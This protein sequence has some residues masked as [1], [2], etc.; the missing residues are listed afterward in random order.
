[1]GSVPEHLA[2]A[3]ALAAAIGSAWA[4]PVAA[5][6]VTY[7]GSLSYSTGSYVFTERTHSFWISNG[8]GVR[9]GRVYLAATLP[10]VAQNSG[11]VT[12]VGGHPLPTGGE[13]NGAV[14]GRGRG[15]RIGSGTSQITDSTVVFRNVY[16]VEVGDPMAS[17]SIEAFQGVGVVRSLSIQAGAKA[18]LRTLESGV[19]TG[20]WDFGGGLS[21]IV[22]SGRT[23]A[24]GDVSYWHFGDLPELELKGSVLYSVGVSRS[25]WDARGSVVVTLAGAS[26][27]MDSVDPPLSLGVGLSYLPRAG[28]SLS[29][30]AS[31]GLTEASP[32]FSSWVG[33]G[34][35]L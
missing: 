13:Q 27:I 12:F 14:S 35:G 1:M 15:M 6:Q 3:V 20:E 23:L 34:V 24:L 5:Q 28:R 25:L 2:R 19:G 29:L 7:T 21:M 30:G 22:G 32:D 17:A 8:L 11:V 31:V 9:A 16:E 18:P 26:R 10:V 4:G 33:W